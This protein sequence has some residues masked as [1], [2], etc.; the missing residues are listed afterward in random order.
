M[1]TN[2]GRGIIKQVEELTLR[3]E[4]LE[5]EKEDLKV[6]SK[7]LS[8]RL[9]E[10]EAKISSEISKAVE[11]A[12]KEATEPLY[13][14]ITELE[15]E[16][17]KLN[18]EVFRL[19][20]QINKNSGNSSK[21]PSTDGF[22]R[23]PNLR[24]H[25]S[26]KPGGQKGHPGRN[27]KL[28]ENLNELVDKG[29]A[30]RETVDHTD[31][32]TPYVSRYVIDVEVNLVVTEHRYAKGKAPRGNEVTYGENIKAMSVLLSTEGIIAEERLSKYFKEITNKAIPISD[33]TIDNFLT[34]FSDSLD[35]EIEEIENCLLNELVMHVDDTPVRCTQKPDYSVEEPVIETSKGT[36]FNSYIRTYSNKDTTLY[37]VNPQKNIE[38]I[39]R[40]G[41]LP[42]Y[43][44]TL[45]HDNEAKFHNY[46][47]RNGL[48]CTH[49]CRDLIGLH[50][51]QKIP[52]ADEMCKFMIALNDHKKAD[53]KSG[54]ESCDQDELEK[55]SRNYDLL[56]EQGQ[57]A[58]SLLKDKE[59]GFDELRKML[60]RL[61]KYK[62]CYLLFIR[63]YKV[64]FSNNQAERDLR[65]IKTKQ[66][67][68]GC[69]RSWEGIKRFTKIR[70]FISTAK[71][72]NL[73]ILESINR[74][75]HGDHV[76]GATI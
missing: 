19:S 67:V 22:K 73:N 2:Y 1:G 61:I 30:R 50:D 45:I 72:R 39:E 51:L 44:K 36:S 15:A 53:Q 41:V 55:F 57:K 7:E 20:N 64:P 23:I 6:Q 52:W 68:S 71:K 27:L 76:L 62:D 38:G 26:R 35:P 74:V 63:D 40:D 48:C 70:S 43:V 17:A 25:S 32:T 9:K 11:E 29:L 46:G 31:G 3:N 37:T 4:Q 24:E 18:A 42:K 59:L 47:I 28:P 16:K 49:L 60:N 8:H 33:A 5:V 56:I 21:P 13:E 65:P 66:K 12:V 75:L 54:K 58:L 14:K 69:F 10:L 34:E